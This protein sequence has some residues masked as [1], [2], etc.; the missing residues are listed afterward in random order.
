M[1]EFGLDYL[2]MMGVALMALPK[3]YKQK[4]CQPSAPLISPHSRPWRGGKVQNKRICGFN[5][6]LILYQAS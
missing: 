1:K 3:L 6:S 5:Y 4:S 2:D